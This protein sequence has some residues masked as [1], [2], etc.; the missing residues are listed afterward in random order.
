MGRTIVTFLNQLIT[1]IN[2]T[3]KRDVTLFGLATWWL[4]FFS[5]YNEITLLSMRCNK[6][7]R[8]IFESLN[9]LLTIYK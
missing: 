1:A 4:T 2:D 3:V 9:S 6:E 8:C 5:H 7:K